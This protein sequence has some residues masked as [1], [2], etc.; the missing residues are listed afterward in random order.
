MEFVLDPEL[1]TVARGKGIYELAAYIMAGR[2][3]LRAGITQTY[4]KP[5]SLLGHIAYPL[6]LSDSGTTE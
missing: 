3:V 4:D 1:T 6:V 2:C 5:Y